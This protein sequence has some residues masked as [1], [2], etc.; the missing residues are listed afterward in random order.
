M[1]TVIHVSNVMDGVAVREVRSQVPMAVVVAKGKAHRISSLGPQSL[2]ATGRLC[3][4]H[5]KKGTLRIH[6]QPAINRRVACRKP[7]QE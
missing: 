1:L 6:L 5:A 7:F 2:T 4:G 3:E